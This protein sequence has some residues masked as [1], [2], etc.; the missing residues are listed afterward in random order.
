MEMQAIGETLSEYMLYLLIKQPDM[1]A[2]TPGIGLLRYGDTC[3]EA[4]RFFGSLEAWIDGHD[5]ARRM[6]LG[7]N[8][9]EKPSVVKG[10][11]SKSALFDGVI[12]AKVLREL[13][14]ELMWDVITG[15]WGEM[16]MYAAGSAWGSCTSGSS[17]VAAS[18]SRSSGSSW[19]TWGQG[20]GIRFGKKKNSV[21]T[22]LDE[23]REN[24]DELRTQFGEIS[25]RKA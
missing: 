8:T 9:S 10:D 14:E 15:V 24:S 17:A 11:R 20:F 5:D 23:F 16:L 25:G 3:E 1:V 19:R 22:E 21:P 2:A 7:V 12:L 13:D 18:S 6:L 4:R